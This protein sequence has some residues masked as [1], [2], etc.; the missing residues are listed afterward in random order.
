MSKNNSSTKV[1]LVEDDK[2]D[3]LAFKRA[4]KKLKIPYDYSIASS[5]A[6]AR[7][8]LKAEKFDI[9]I[10]DYFLGDG[11]A[12]DFF[13]IIVDTPIIVTTGAGDEEI[14]ISAMKAGAYDYLIKDEERN[15]IKV[16]PLTVDKAIKSRSTERQIKLLSHALMSTTDSVYITDMDDKIIFVNKAF[17]GI[18]GYKEDDIIGKE[19]GILFAGVL[20]KSDKKLRKSDFLSLKKDGTEFPVSLSKSVVKDENGKA[21]AVIAVVHDISEHIRMEE[22]WRR[23][24]FLDSLTGIA[25]R[26]NFDEFIDAEWRRAARSVTPISLIMI[27][28]DF[29]KPYNDTYGH[30]A[31]DDCLK[32][33]AASIGTSLKR[34]RELVARYG[35][36]EFVV[37]LPGTELKEA[38]AITESL[39][40][41]VDD[42]KIL[43]ESSKVCKNVTISLGVATIVP[44][45]ESN[46]EQLISDADKA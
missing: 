14:A 31:G 43:H 10:A 46:P 27:D 42:Q 36:E 32:K 12:L 9:I 38:I 5:V 11:N 34:S 37:V 1:L 13:D 45:P 15:Y 3:Q 17:S 35:G 40:K 41:N 18:Y 25:N 4:I 7:E 24:S 2:V 20:N 8:K 23:L 22:A 28:I 26:R 16:L 29:F 33:I 6:E 21:E 19:S 30:Q 39:R 44:G